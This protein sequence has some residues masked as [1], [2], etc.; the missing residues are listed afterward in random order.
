[1]KRIVQVKTSK[2]QEFHDGLCGIYNTFKEVEILDL[3]T[4][5][6]DY[7]VLAVGTE[8]G[9]GESPDCD[10]IIV[11][12]RNGII[13]SGYVCTLCNRLFVAGDH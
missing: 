10:H 1:M 8:Y 3:K 12:A 5:Y 11:D 9:S 6:G 2:E 7:K 13:T 4:D